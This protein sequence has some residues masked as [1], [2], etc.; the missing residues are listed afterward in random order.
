MAEEPLD[1]FDA[2]IDEALQTNALEV[3]EVD[4]DA[5]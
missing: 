3:P 2:D 1:S 5:M 4:E